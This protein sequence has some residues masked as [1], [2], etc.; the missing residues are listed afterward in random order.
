M[1]YI[2][3]ISF[4]LSSFIMVSVGQ[5]SELIHIETERL[6]LI[7][8]SQLGEKAIFQ[9][10]GDKLSTTPLQISK[11]RF[12]MNQ[13]IKE[14]T[15][16][17]IFPAYGRRLY[18]EPA[19]RLVHQDGVLTTDLVYDSHHTKDI[20]DNVTETVIRLK[21]KIYPV[22]VD[23]QFKAYRKENVISQSVCVSHN[24]SK[25]VMIEELAS[26]Y[27]PLTAQSYYLTHFS[28]TWA[29]EMQLIEEK[30]TPGIK[31]VES[32]KGVRTTQ[33]ESPSFLLS[34][35]N[36]VQENSGEIYAGSLAWSGN[37]K[38]SFEFD[39]FGRLHV[40][41]GMN[42]FASS[43]KLKA[44]ESFQTPENIMTY[45]SSGMGEISRNYHN[46]S[47]KYAL[48]HGGQLR[49][50]VLNSWEGA[51]FSFNEQT[52]MEMID[53]A[54]EFGVEMFVMDDGWFGNKY[55]RNN[56]REGL[57]DWQVNRKKIP[58]GIDFLARYA[59]NKGL[60]FGI[61]IEPEMVNPKSELAEKH[62][63]WI[64][65]SGDREMLT[66]RNQWLLDLS[67]P[68]VQD[69]VVKTF[70]DVL[71]LSEHISYI[72]WDANR[73]VDNV[74]SDYLG[75]EEQT[76]FWIEYTR[77]L[78]KVYE[79]IRVSHPDVMIQLC[80]SGGGRLDFGALRFHDE[81]WA[82]DNT[83]PLNR[84]FIQY[85][86]SLFF[87]AMATASHVST[88]PN[89]QTGMVTPLKFRFDVAMSQRLGLELQLKDIA[90]DDK[91]F[92]TEAI[93]TYKK[94][95][96]IVQ[97]GDLYRLLSPNNE[98]GWSASL[99]VDRKQSHAVLFAYSLEFHSRTEYF[100]CKLKGLDPNKRYRLEELN[101][102]NNRK[103]FW[104][105]GKTFTGEELMKIGINLQ[106]E[107]IF[108]SSVIL[109]SEI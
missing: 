66:I 44:G 65:K 104:A 46:W 22:W 87:P 32:K 29:N 41:S 2:V 9:Y 8:T 14:S 75:A 28:G 105:D 39:E 34:L 99:Y 78:Y 63:E 53:H 24:E 38:L 95:R 57:G 19:I 4:F 67:N 76:H 5:N 61:W 50:V 11:E 21:D 85:S 36:P 18:M 43:Y 96:P 42:P 73:H 27:L 52:I 26:S 60:R 15:A 97:F 3:F 102:R 79:R 72:K 30:L 89:H 31:K 16:P 48:A 20:D 13:D 7:F 101:T 56:D 58:G 64:V 6:S 93:R 82:S 106:I 90:G 47:R 59:V 80:S 40:L 98:G 86:T 71:S 103:S 25:P 100:E 92:V 62:P 69:F 81:F 55:P 84:L 10:F 83:N 33:S 94:I 37:Y 68:K 70:N 88:S 23:L 12:K 35:N 54:A 17:E 108:D 51:Y 49:P 91:V 77:G 1:K 107:A 45:S 109:L 74:G